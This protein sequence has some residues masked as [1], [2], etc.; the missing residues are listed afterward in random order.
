EAVLE[1]VRVLSQGLHPALLSRA[2]LGPSLKVLARRSPIP[3]EVYVEVNERPPP[4]IETAVYYVV[5]EAIT[6]PIKH[7]EASRTS[8]IVA[9][10]ALDL[11]ASVADDGVGGAELG[12]GSGLIGLHDRV[13]ALGGRVV[14]ESPV[15]AGTTISVALPI[16]APARP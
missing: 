13:E 4:S 5:S 12:T 2:G 6:N 10:D 15:G 8:V 3:V 7:S 14:L 1:E 9:D 11:R 16:G